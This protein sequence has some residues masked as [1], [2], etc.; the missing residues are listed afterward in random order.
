MS[1]IGSN[2]VRS[3]WKHRDIHLN[4]A[5]SLAQNVHFTSRAETAR[6]LADAVFNEFKKRYTDETVDRWLKKAK[7]V[8]SK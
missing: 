8:A 7:W 2:S 6:H 5:L 4:F 3:K 1:N